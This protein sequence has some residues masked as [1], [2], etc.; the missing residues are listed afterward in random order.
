MNRRTILAGVL[1]AILTCGCSTMQVSSDFSPDAD[2]SGLQTYAWKPGPQGITDDPRI[3]NDILERRIRTAIDDQLALQGFTRTSGGVPDFF[4]GF[5]A[6]VSSKLE[7]T[8]INQHYGYAPGWGTHGFHGRGP[9]GYRG[10]MWGWEPPSTNVRSFEQGSLIIDVVE[11]ASDQLIW[12][13]TAQAE[14][15]FSDDEGKKE[16]RVR[17]A[18]ARILKPFPPR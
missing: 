18:V 9:G 10:Y 8:A 4:V 16:K 17:E 1:L 6:A 5:H 13:G 11:P 15:G 3:D 14:V 2:F 7:V 12:R